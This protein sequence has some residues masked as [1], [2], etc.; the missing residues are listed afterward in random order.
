MVNETVIIYDTSDIKN[1]PKK[2]ISLEMRETVGD[3]KE[4]KKTQG[5][6]I[7]QNLWP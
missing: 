5:N 4:W 3:H 2:P 1:T 6:D 7:K